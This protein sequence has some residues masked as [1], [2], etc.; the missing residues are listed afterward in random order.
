MSEMKESTDRTFKPPDEEI[1]MGKL[2][3][4]TSKDLLIRKIRYGNRWYV[5]VRFFM[6]TKSFTG[7]SWKGIAL[8]FEELTKIIEILQKC[9]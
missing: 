9:V 7:Y 8:P 3:I 2:P 4:T 1:E 5:D 6:K